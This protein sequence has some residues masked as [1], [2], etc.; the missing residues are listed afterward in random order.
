MLTEKDLPALISRAIS[1]GRELTWLEFKTNLSDPEQIA[2]TVSAIANSAAL[3]GV[4]Y[5]ALIWGIEDKSLEVVGTTFDPYA[6]KRGNEALIPWLHAQVQDAR[7]IEFIT[8]EYN[9]Y[10][11]VVLGVGASE[12]TPTCFQGKPYIRVDSHTVE[13]TR[14]KDIQRRLWITLIDTDPEQSI[15]I[16]G[17]SKNDLGDA[18][19]FE[20]ISRHLSI[21]TN[22]LLPTITRLN[23]AS[24][25]PAG[26]FTVPVWSALIFARD[27][28]SI[29]AIRRKSLRC[30][31]YEGEQRDQLERDLSSNEGYLR[32]YHQ[33]V[34]ALDTLLP[35]PE[36]DFGARRT[37]VPRFSKLALNEAIGNALA[38]QDLSI[39]GAGPIIEVFSNRIEVCNPG[40]PLL[41]T[42]H[43]VNAP[44]QSR[45]EQLASMMR[46][47]ELIQERGSGWDIIAMES[48]RLNMPAPRVE[49][50]SKQFRVIFRPEQPLAR[51]PKDEQLWTLYI[52]A[53]LKWVDHEPI[54]N[55]IV[56][57]R[58]S[59]PT[60]N[61]A[62]AS[63][64]IGEAVSAGLLRPFDP[65]AGRGQMQYV[66]AW[67]Q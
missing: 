11:M 58:F 32:A 51:L 10:R 54:S 39:S 50:I 57:E 56:R 13:L 43:L 38:H 9:G 6:S 19:D 60:A 31:T 17:L 18:L 48:A 66:P 46:R 1:A 7:W 20:S 24:V 27:L 8:C 64:L 45:N 33:I 25:D 2:K 52:H 26:S 55:S 14:H 61:S 21:P 67:A 40:I 4:S 42:L 62:T 47:L 29:A 41:D 5:G 65:N 37:G 15:A 59:I 36:R 28:S 3:A 12:H 63:R 34:V 53:C 35:S 30:L 16:A 22:Q 44:P 49:S 23:I